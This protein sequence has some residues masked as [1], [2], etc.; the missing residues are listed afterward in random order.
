MQYVSQSYCI[1][2]LLLKVNCKKY[3]YLCNGYVLY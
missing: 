3:V 2:E 1:D